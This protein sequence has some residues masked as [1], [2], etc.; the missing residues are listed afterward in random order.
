MPF[1]DQLNKDDNNFPNYLGRSEY[2]QGGRQL[3]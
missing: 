3:F 2:L 1:V